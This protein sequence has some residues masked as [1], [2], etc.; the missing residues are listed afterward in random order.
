MKRYIKS[1]N[2]D[3]YPFLDTREYNSLLWYIKTEARKFGL[4][5]EYYDN[6]DPNDLGGENRDRSNAVWIYDANGN[7]VADF[8]IEAT[9]NDLSVSCNGRRNTFS[10]FADAKEYIAE[11]LEEV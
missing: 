8:L 11:M 4:V 6:P 9:K 2:Y 5:A 10:S 3:Y 1:A 7:E